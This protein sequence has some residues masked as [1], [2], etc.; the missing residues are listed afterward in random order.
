LESISPTV[1]RLAKSGEQ[2]VLRQ[3]VLI[4]VL[5]LGSF[6]GV[7]SAEERS[8]DEIRK[9]LTTKKKIR[10]RG[11]RRSPPTTLPT[12]LRQLRGRTRGLSITER[13]DLAVAVKT[14]SVPQIDIEIL[15]EYNSAKLSAASKSQLVKLG[16]ALASRELSSSRVVI[17]GHT[18]GKGS[19]DYNQRLSE[20]RAASVR[21]FL[22]STF[23]LDIDKLIIVGYG[24]EQL[25]LPEQPFD[26]ANRRVQVLNLG[27][28]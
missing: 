21:T 8:S 27:R 6:T 12:S 25:K 22:I 9:A 15:F 4:C 20:Q 14:G 18:D 16:I 3:L 11:L 17:A 26:A 24:K 2:T 10:T 13:Q 19:A 23:G 5:L 7:A 28:R 1:E